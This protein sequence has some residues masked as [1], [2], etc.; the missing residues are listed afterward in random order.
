V[1]RHDAFFGDGEDL[2]QLA[3]SGRLAIVLPD[4]WT[5]RDFPLVCLV[6]QRETR[7]VAADGHALHPWCVWP[8]S[9]FADYLVDLELRALDEVAAE[10][11]LPE[12]IER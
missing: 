2:L 12:E 3:T 8:A 10:V 4:G 7:L 1:L 9:T 6:C 5:A 11:Q